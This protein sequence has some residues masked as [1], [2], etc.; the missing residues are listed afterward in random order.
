MAVMFEDQVVP[1]T[2]LA[3]VALPK[4]WNNQSQ[5]VQLFELGPSSE[6]WTICNKMMCK[7]MEVC[8]CYKSY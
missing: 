7:P 1:G 8:N 6:E 4:N 5:C 3:E 2:S